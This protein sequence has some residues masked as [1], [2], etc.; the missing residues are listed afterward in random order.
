MSALRE[1]SSALSDQILDLL[2]HAEAL[3]HDRLVALSA[4]IGHV[5]ASMVD[6]CGEQA[7]RRLRDQQLIGL[8][9]IITVAI[10]AAVAGAGRMQ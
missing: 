1:T 2:D 4:A 5:V 10:E 7:A 9:G 6:V 8:H 3:P